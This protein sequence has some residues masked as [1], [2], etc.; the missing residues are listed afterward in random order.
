MNFGR[1]FLRLA[2]AFHAKPEPRSQSPPVAIRV[3]GPVI[4]AEQS[5]DIR[6]RLDEL[7]KERIIRQQPK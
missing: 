1:L 5:A 2:R 4:V 7:S 3:S 6:E